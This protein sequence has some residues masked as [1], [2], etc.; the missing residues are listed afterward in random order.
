[1]DLCQACHLKRGTHT[2]PLVPLFGYGRTPHSQP[3]HAEVCGLSPGGRDPPP[4]PPPALCRL[5]SAQNRLE[6]VSKWIGHRSINTTFSVYWDVGL[7]QATSGS[8]RWLVASTELLQ[9]M[10]MPSAPT[11]R[12]HTERGHCSHRG[13]KRDPCP[14]SVFFLGPHLA[15]KRKS[16]LTAPGDKTHVFFQSHKVKQVR[17]S[18]SRMLR[19]R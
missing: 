15:P 16:I 2:P 17:W 12:V 13:C 3:C 4:S 5:M 6:M 18:R 1:M 10:N 14:D 8:G 9:Y 19:K 7:K 11:V